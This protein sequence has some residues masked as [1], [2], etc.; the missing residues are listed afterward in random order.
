M[1]EATLPH[2]LIIL[3]PQCCTIGRVSVDCEPTF[4]WRKVSSGL[5]RL[6]DSLQVESGLIPQKPHC[7]SSPVQYSRSY[8]LNTRLHANPQT[9]SP[10]C[11]QPTRITWS[12]ARFPRPSNLPWLTNQS[13][14]L[15]RSPFTTTPPLPPPTDGFYSSPAEKKAGLLET[16]FL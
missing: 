2:Q 7:D 13:T 8:Q 11:F 6:R 4:H 5:T 9:H 12:L 15:S 1:K 3:N 16:L 14:L 10:A